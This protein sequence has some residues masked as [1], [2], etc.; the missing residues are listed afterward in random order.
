MGCIIEG[1][2]LVMGGTGGGTDD[3]SG[4]DIP[5]PGTPGGSGGRGMGGGTGGKVGKA[6]ILGI[7]ENKTSRSKN[8]ESWCDLVFL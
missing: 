2:P 4:G 1:A 3:T 7:P 5:T 8:G 6:P